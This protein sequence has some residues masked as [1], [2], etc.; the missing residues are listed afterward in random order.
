[1]VKEMFTYLLVFVLLDP[2]PL[3]HVHGEAER[4]F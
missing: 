3:V 2:P 1:M 4:T